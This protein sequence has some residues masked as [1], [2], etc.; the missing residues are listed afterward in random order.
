MVRKDRCAFDRRHPLGMT[1]PISCMAG[2]GLMEGRFS[3]WQHA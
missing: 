1:A 3:A 2:F